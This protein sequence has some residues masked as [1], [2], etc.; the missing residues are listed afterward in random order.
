[1][2]GGSN[3]AMASGCLARSARNARNESWV[4]PLPSRNG[5]IALRSARKRRHPAQGRRVNPPEAIALAE[6]AEQ[7]THLPV[8]MLG[9]TERVAALGDPHRADPAGPGIYILEQMAVKRA[10]VAVT[11]P[12]GRQGLRRALGG[13]LGLMAAAAEPAPAVK[14]RR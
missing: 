6:S 5:W 3:R 13:H 7:P 10:R 9:I 1:M 2:A 12:A 11:E 8:D 14:F 4:R